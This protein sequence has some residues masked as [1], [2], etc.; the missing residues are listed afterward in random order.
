MAPPTKTRGKRRKTSAAHG[1]GNNGRRSRRAL[2][3]EEARA[4][5]FGRGEALDD[6]EIS[7]EEDK[8]EVDEMDHDAAVEEPAET[9]EATRLRLAREFLAE[10]KSRVEDSDDEEEVAA[11]LA[12]SRTDARL[13]IADEASFGA[14]A[15]AKFSGHRGPVT[16]LAITATTVA[17]AS[18]DN[19]VTDFDVETGLE[20]RRYLD[21][22]PRRGPVAIEKARGSAADGDLAP[23]QSHQAEVLC[24]AAT[25][26]L[27]AC[28]GRDRLVHV[29]DRRIGECVRSLR[30]HSK[31][32]T[33]LCFAND[34]LYSASEDGSVKVWRD[35]VAH[36]ET[37]YGH[38]S[39]VL[40]LDAWRDRP[41]T[42]G[43]DAALRSWKL[44]DE[45]HLVYRAAPGSSVDACC[46]VDATAFVSGGDDGTLCFWSTQRKKPTAV[47]RAAHGGPD[48]APHWISAVGGFR[49]ADLVASG[50][51]SGAIRFFKAPSL[52]PVATIDLDAVVT[53]LASTPDLRHL[54]VAASHEHR[55]G[56]WFRN[57]KAPNAV[58]FYPITL[59]DAGHQ[60]P[61][62][63]RR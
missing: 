23:R 28:G 27:L 2:E 1:A 54:A 37:L 39:A 47:V 52:D 30:G 36:A 4:T 31:A 53:G 21:R 43:A 22:W 49:N 45:T 8:D 15:V 20:T 29:F 40:C 44:K 63:R 41:L 12:E 11:A 3:E 14:S 34:D 62:S 48:H 42:G 57:K 61:P 56:R 19:S 9:I 17:S 46:C 60:H 7:S 16:C 59:A 55:L 32:V 33:G 24:L 5:F 50:S 13:E 18:K 51:R 10:T 26:K 38:E 35:A 6:E 58:L 25:D